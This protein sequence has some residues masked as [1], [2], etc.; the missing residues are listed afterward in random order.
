MDKRGGHS[1]S[2]GVRYTTLGSTSG[3][4]QIS[5]SP[6][7]TRALTIYDGQ[8]Y[9]SAATGASP[10]FYGVATVGTGLPTTAGQSITI[11]PG[12]PTTS[13][14]TNYGFVFA[15]ANTLY[16]TD[17]RN[18]TAGGVQKW[19]FSGGTW[20]YQ[21]TLN[22][23]A[24]F[25]ARGIVGDFSGSDPILYVT[26]REPS[27]NHIVKIVDK[28]ATSSTFSTLAT[29]PTGTIFRGIAWAPTPANQPPVNTLP[30]TFAATE[31]TDAF[32][33]GISVADPDASSAN[34]KV[35]FSIPAG[36]GTLTVKTDVSGGI[37]GGDITNSGNGTETVEI[38]AS[39][40]AINATL[41]DA[42]GLKFTPA[43]DLNSNTN[44][45]DVTLTMVSDD[46]GNTGNGGAKSD[47]DT[48]DISIAPVADTPSVTNAATNED[49]QTTSGLVICAMQRME[50]R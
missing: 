49:T 40:A 15:D 37:T 34:I 8:L 30:S 7:D 1:S 4:I 38:T 11:L 36:M 41:A 20:T 44:G 42:N 31:D 24:T 13:G 22:P 19:T 35:T 14:P 9:V 12:F 28:G 25:G 26:T 29:A 5:N 17:D 47:S 6:T 50:V 45:G 33:T 39:L 16:V 48:S 3:S 43:A 32:L 18:S 2:G 23:G 10:G 27:A 21:Y 46:L